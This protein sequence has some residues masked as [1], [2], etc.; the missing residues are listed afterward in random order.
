MHSNPSVTICLNFYNID[1]IRPRHTKIYAVKMIKIWD[2]MFVE[3]FRI[4]VKMWDEILVV[5]RA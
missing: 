1:Y 3:T 2:E 5:N 4:T